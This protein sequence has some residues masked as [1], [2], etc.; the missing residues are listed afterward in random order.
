MKLVNLLLD[1]STSN[2]YISNT[3]I[4]GIQ[5]TLNKR[6]KIILYLNKR[7]QFSSVVCN[8]C[9]YLFQCNYCD[10]SMSV[11]RY[12]GILLCHLCTHKEHIPLECKK[13]RGTQLSHIGIGTQQVEEQLTTLFPKTRIFRFDTDT[14]RTKKSKSEALQTLEDS[15]III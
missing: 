9:Q 13:C 5:D 15:E 8:D 2:P 10:I 1:K 4:T 7:G 3:L 12:P 14:M 6:E 11:H